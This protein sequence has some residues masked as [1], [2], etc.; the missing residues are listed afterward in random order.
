MM[1]AL[2]RAMRASMTRV[3][4]SVQMARLRKPR[5]CWELVRSTSRRLP[6]YKAVPRHARRVPHAATYRRNL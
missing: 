1:M 4:R 6:A 2:A 5:V 3:R